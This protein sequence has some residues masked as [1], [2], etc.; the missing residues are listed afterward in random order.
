M[1]TN[2]SFPSQKV[3]DDTRLRG[4]SLSLRGP[5]RHPVIVD[6]NVTL[7]QISTLIR[8]TNFKQMDNLATSCSDISNT[9]FKPV[10][11]DKLSRKI[12]ETRGIPFVSISGI[13][14]EVGKHNIQ[15]EIIEPGGQVI[16]ISRPPSDSTPWYLR[17]R[18]ADQLDTDDKGNVRFGFLR[19][20]FEMLT[21][22]PKPTSELGEVP[23]CYAS[24]ADELAELAQHKNF[25]NVFLMTFRTF[26]TADQLF[27]MLVE[28]FRLEPN[29]SLTES[30]YLNWKANLRI[31]VQRL[32]LDI[33]SRWLE[34]YQLLEEEPHI[35]QR[36]KR[37]LNQT[38]S[39]PHNKNTIIQTIDRMVRWVIGLSV[40]SD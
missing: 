12:T 21:F 22:P 37:F 14:K 7:S 35:A 31:P 36:L 32:V 9:V 10:Q 27:D 30:E 29:E 1:S 20:L 8:S 13:D 2:F 23:A 17:P 5:R 16:D 39:L 18:Y 4:C 34:N 15:G 28:R 33:F 19:S 11:E 6:D 24:D 25:T 38:N 3:T 40:L 26:T